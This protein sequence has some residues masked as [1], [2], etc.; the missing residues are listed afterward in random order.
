MKNNRLFSKGLI[1]LS[2]LVLFV[3]AKTEVHSEGITF[4]AG[5]FKAAKQKAK[6]E[7][8]MI[9]IDAYTQ[10]CGPCKSMS[11]NVFTLKSVGTYYNSNFINLKVDMEEAEGLFIG[12]KYQ[13]ARYPTFLFLDANGKLIQKEEGSVNSDVFIQ[14][15]KTALKLNK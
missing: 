7:N 3:Q 6:T 15:G 9:F 10:W 8:K 5:T 14:Y 1:A 2:I 12:K 4:F 11:K 13:V